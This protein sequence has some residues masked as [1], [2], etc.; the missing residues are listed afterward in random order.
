M[1]SHLLGFAILM[2]ASSAMAAPTL[3]KQFNQRGDF[4]L[5]GNTSG[6][7]CAGSAGMPVVGTVG[8]CGANLGDSAADIYWRA[9]DP[10]AGQV[11]ADTGVTP[12]QARSTALLTQND[13]PMGATV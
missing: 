8:A 10:M 9:D 11:H 7:D 2:S 13:L 6:Y 4:A 1:R 3:R 5:I 12:A